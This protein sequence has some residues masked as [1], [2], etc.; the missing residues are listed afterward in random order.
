M[1][2]QNGPLSVCRIRGKMKRRTRIREGEDL[3]AAYK[4]SGRRA[5]AEGI[6]ED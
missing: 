4:Q 2:C 3:Q 1:K 6:T 5:E